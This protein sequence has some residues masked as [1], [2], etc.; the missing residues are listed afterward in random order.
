M[1]IVD[2][3]LEYLFIT[4]FRKKKTISSSI[5]LIVNATLVKK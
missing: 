3:G 5:S 4:S 1:E 2:Q